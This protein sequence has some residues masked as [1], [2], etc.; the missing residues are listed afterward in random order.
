MKPDEGAPHWEVPAFAAGSDEQRRVLKHQDSFAVFDPYGDIGEHPEQGIYHGG[1]RYLSHYRLTLDGHRPLLLN[2]AVTQDNALLAV[3]LTTHDLYRDG[4]LA[5]PKTTLHVFRS[6]LLCTGA[7]YEHLRVKNHGLAPVSV[8]LALAFAADYADIFEVRGIR[9]A[10]RGTL[11]PSARSD[12][13]L[14]LGYRG[15]DGRERRSR[16]RLPAGFRDDGSDATSIALDLPAGGEIELDITIAFELDAQRPQPA[17][18]AAAR[19]R[20]AD[21]AAAARAERASVRTSNAQFNAWLGRSAADLHML[22]TA[23]PEGLYPY[24]GVPWYSTAFGRDGIVTALQTLWLTPRIARG[25]LGFLAA[26]Q[27]RD[28]VPAQDAEPGKI[29]HELRQGEMAALREVP[30]GRYYGSIDAT[31]LFVVL[32]GAYY[33]RTGD[34][35]CIRELWGAI[36]RALAW[37]E[38]YGDRDGDGFVEYAPQS[39]NGLTQQGWKD[40]EDSVFHADGRL[41]KF[42]IALCEVQGYVYAAWEA[43]AAL[44]AALGSAGLAA[45]YLERARV[46]AERFEQ[47]FWCEELGS[48][49][50]ALDGDKRQCKVLASNAGHALFS[51][52]AGRA[53][54]ARVAQTLLSERMFS[55]WGIRTLGHGEPRYNPMSYH[56]GSVWPH[57]N[58]I[59]CAGLS[60]Y[61]H[62][63]EVLRVMGGMFDAALE[64]EQQ[65]LP[66]LFCGFRRKPEQGPTLYPVACSPQAWASASVF[67]F[68]QACLGIGFDLETPRLRF[69][70]PRLPEYLDQMTITNL[71]VG[72]AV[73]D[74]SLVRHR[75]DVGVNLTRVEGEIE[76]GVLV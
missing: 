1:T 47:A 26:H 9:R 45:G 43:A 69:L 46:L 60:R 17:H 73:V 8:T 37:I 56:N 55:G 6:K 67:Q 24:A 4:T 18:Y 10:R 66:E 38:R 50:L 36:E 49:A 61:G 75:H 62:R 13:E 28:T 14:C 71:R 16:I 65:R 70:R 48:Y 76:V 3:D 29:L 27:A 35:A 30:F 31:P 51:G 42:P 41:A 12:G 33:T 39:A 7:Y 34:L 64:V 44:A 68:L 54:A 11:L 72:E 20:C 53:H 32:A 57:D 5:V 74:L 59:V 25:V 52:I 58:S 15:L 23:L 2:S 22:L 19:T 63:D 40:S 21:D